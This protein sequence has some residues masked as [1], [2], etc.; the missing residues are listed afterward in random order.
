MRSILILSVFTIACSTVVPVT[1][2]GSSGGGSTAGGS[3]AGGSTAG[4]STA[5]GSTAGGSTAGGSTAG[6]STAGGSTAGGSTAGGSTAGGSTA[7]GSAVCAPLESAYVTAVEAAKRCPLNAL[8]NPC[9]ATRPNVVTCG[10]QTFIDPNNAAPVDA[11][12]NQY[13]D[14]GCVMTACPRC[15]PLDAGVCVPVDGGSVNDG[16]CLDLR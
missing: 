8:V 11:I 16:V 5:G 10:C 14:A 9:T 15:A 7:G 12:Q 13:T 2:G 4:G 6:G 3:A 1:D